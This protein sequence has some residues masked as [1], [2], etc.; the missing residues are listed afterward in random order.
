M[1]RA[2]AAQKI[3]TPGLDPPAGH[4]ML[5]KVCEWLPSAGEGPGVHLFKK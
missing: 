3:V 2:F 5:Q 4:S 1:R